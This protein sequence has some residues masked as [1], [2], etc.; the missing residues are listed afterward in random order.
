MV[1]YHIMD[2]LANFANGIP[3][4]IIAEINLPHLG[5]LTSNLG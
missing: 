5:L 4:E 2:F 3:L 1:G